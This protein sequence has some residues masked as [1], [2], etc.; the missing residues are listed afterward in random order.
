MPSQRNVARLEWSIK[1]DEDKNCIVAEIEVPRFLD[2]SEIDVDVHPHWFQVMV[3]GKLL[4][5]HLPEEVSLSAS[6]TDVI[7]F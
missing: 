2:T 6:E 5:L 1:D 3:K 4:L 7:M